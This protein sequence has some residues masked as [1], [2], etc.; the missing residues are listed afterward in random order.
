MTKK[1]LNQIGKQYLSIVNTKD[2]EGRDFTYLVEFLDELGEKVM[3]NKKNESNE[4]NEEGV[5]HAEGEDRV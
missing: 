2:S 1:V 3:I 5:V 4:N